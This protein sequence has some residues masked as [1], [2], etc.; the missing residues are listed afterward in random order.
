MPDLQFKI[1]V[2]SSNATYIKHS[3]NQLKKQT[4]KLV[5]YRKYGILRIFRIKICIFYFN[6]LF[7]KFDIKTIKRKKVCQSGANIINFAIV[8]VNCDIIGKCSFCLEH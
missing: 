2:E 3:R 1:N 7:L 5:F 8:R 6:Y 4:E